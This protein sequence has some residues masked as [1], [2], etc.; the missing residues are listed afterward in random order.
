MRYGYWLYFFNFKYNIWVIYIKTVGIV[1]RSFNENN[2]SFIGNREDLYDKIMSYGVMVI[3]IPISLDFELIKELACICDGIILPGGDNFVDNDFKLV[4]YLYDNDIPTLGICLGMQS[5]SEYFNGRVDVNV[6]GHHSTN[7]YVHP[8][9]ICR[10]S[11]LYKIL[12]KDEI[13][14]NS[15]HHSA[16][17]Y[18]NL[19]VSARSEDGVIEAIESDEKDF[20][21]GLEW[22]PESL[23]D[24]NTNKIFGYFLSLL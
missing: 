8:I 12:G 7:E 15:R 13:M 11:L 3:G 20:F 16:I 1:M 23:C 22:H 5:M 17:P 14:V 21:L 18:T 6:E 10:D 2:K 9:S 19:K 24:D 4:E